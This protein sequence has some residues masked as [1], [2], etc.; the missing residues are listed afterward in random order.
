MTTARDDSKN[1]LGAIKGLGDIYR[2][3]PVDKAKLLGEW[4]KL[5]G[6][7]GKGWPRGRVKGRPH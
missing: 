7:E 2:T 4:P 5:Q 3:K 6:I 1:I